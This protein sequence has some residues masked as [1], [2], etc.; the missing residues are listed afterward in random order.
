MTPSVG[1]EEILDEPKPEEGAIRH[2]GDERDFRRPFGRNVEGTG[3]LRSFMVQKA[4]QEPALHGETSANLD[5]SNLPI[6]RFLAQELL[7]VPCCALP[8]KSWTRQS[9]GGFG[10]V[11]AFLLAFENE[12]PL[13]QR[14]F[15][16]RA[17]R[18]WGK[19]SDYDRQNQWGNPFLLAPTSNKSLCRKLIKSVLGTTERKTRKIMSQELTTNSAVSGIS[20]RRC[21]R[22]HHSA[23]FDQA[24]YNVME[25]T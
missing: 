21:Q 3:I 1:V 17:I 23:G 19:T 4:W 7:D 14:I 20:V 25:Q 11:S 18:L 15:P 9:T 6:R 24:I 22:L 8:T 2:E 12:V 5:G 13:P 10:K 16:V